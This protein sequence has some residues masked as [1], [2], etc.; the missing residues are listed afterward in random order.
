MDF[1]Y[2]KAASDLDFSYDDNELHG[3]SQWSKQWPLCAGA[4]QSP[5]NIP[6]EQCEEHQSEIRLQHF[7]GKQTPTNVSVE[8]NG[9]SSEVSSLAVQPVANYQF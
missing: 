6:V 8:N 1:V 9:Y 3:P 5:I 4:L 7:N 2:S